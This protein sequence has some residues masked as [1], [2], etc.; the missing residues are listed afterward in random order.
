MKRIFHV[1]L[2]LCVLSLLAATTPPKP[3]QEAENAIDQDGLLEH[4]RVLGSD[5]FEGRAPGSKGEEESANYITAQFKK[6]GLK[7]GNPNGTY[8]QEVPLAGIFATPTATFT[9]GDQ[10]MELH[11]PDE[12]VAFTQQITPHVNVDDSEMVF[13]GYGVE[14]PEYGWDDFK[15]MDVK[16]KTLVFLINDPPVPSSDDPSKLDEKMFKGKAMTYYGRWS[17][18]YEIAAA[19]G[20]AAAVIVH[21]T[22]PAAYPWS[23][24]ENSNAK[25]NFVI[26]APDKNMN[27]VGVR[28]WIQLETA[29]KL[30]A[31]AGKSYDGLKKAAL[32][33]DFKPVSLG[34][35]ASFALQNEITHFK[36]HNVVGKLEGSD[37]AKRDGY[38]IYSAH[39][40]HL[41]RDPKLKGDQIYNGALDNASG[42]A[43]ILELAQAFTKLPQPPPRSILFMATTAEEA[44]L[45]GAKYYAEHPLYPLDHTLADINI[46]GVNPWGETRDIEDIAAGNSTLDDLLAEDAREAGRVA[47]PNSE[48]EKGTFFRADNFEFAKVGVPALYIGSKPKDYLGQPADYGQK[49]SDDY[50]LHHYHQVS[51]EVNSKWNLSGAVEDVRLLFEVGYQVANGDRYPTWRPDSEFKGKLRR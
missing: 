9:I 14:A 42:V 34:A 28:S 50:T 36:S 21:E 12:F 40:D 44:G 43:S 18:K 48:P 30:F 22:I 20:A 15:G 46:D 4:I 39:W 1:S 24:V 27:T 29:R 51:D 2:A 25:T 45:L 35:K 26:D 16:G 8:T 17:Y 37:P 38:I 13:V 5:K 49:K 19:K 31:A 41:G 10:K 47:K 7:P 23:V 32:S 11:S 6:L 3:P 33:K